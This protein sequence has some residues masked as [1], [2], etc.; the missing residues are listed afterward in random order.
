MEL[1]NEM[2]P[3]FEEAL[4]ATFVS[5]TQKFFDTIPLNQIFIN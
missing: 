2:Q 5:I 3:A 4:S 1:L